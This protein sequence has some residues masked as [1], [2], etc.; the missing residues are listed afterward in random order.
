[1]K[2]DFNCQSDKKLLLNESSKTHF[3]ALSDISHIICEGYLTF[4]YLLNESKITVSKPLKWFEEELSNLCFLRLNRNTLV[5]LIHARVF[6]FKPSPIIE[7]NG[8]LTFPI[9]RR[10]IKVAKQILKPFM[11]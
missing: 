8:G 9:A 3:V 5:N 7:L 10:R 1:M 11:E 4:I 6:K 2:I